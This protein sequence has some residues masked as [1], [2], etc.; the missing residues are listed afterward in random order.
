M[1]NLNRQD[2]EILGGMMNNNDYQSMNNMQLNR[3]MQQEYGNSMQQSN[4]AGNMQPYP[5]AQPPVTY[6]VINRPMTER[7][8]PEEFR[9]ISAWGYFGYN[10]L[11]A[12]PLVGFIMLLVYS[13]GGTNKVNL[14]N[15]AR[16]YFCAFIICIIIFVILAVTGV[17]SSLTSGS[18]Y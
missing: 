17:L 14:R 2:H 9:P 1:K 4:P 18:R 3:N 12:I 6:N 11:F 7:D 8:L 5:A 15:Y 16:S 10:L 13:L